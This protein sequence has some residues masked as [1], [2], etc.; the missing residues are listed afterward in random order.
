MPTDLGAYTAEL[1]SAFRSL[2]ERAGLGFVVD[3]PAGGGE[4]F[5]DREMWEKIVFNLLS[6][7][8]KYTLE[9]EIRVTIRE[10]GA[11]AELT[12]EDTGT[13]IAASELPHI[14]ER[15]H[16]IENVGPGPTKAR[17]SGWPWSRSS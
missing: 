7:A 13:G 17:A 1:A 2:V 14:F 10:T 15:F 5:V 9:G 11:R 3:C 6:N 4:V 12:V 16:R 8:F